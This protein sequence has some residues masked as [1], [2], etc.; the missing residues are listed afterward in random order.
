ME[1]PIFFENLGQ[2]MYGMLHRPDGAQSAPAVVMF[3]GFT[4]H[5]TEVHCL[6]VRA[7]RSLMARGI[8]VLRFDFRGSGESEGEFSQMT[9]DGEVGDGLRAVEFLASRPGVDPARIGV[10]GMS[11]GGCVAACVAA[12]SSRVKAAVLWAAVGDM[13]WLF[14]PYRSRLGQEGEPKDKIDLGGNVISR[15]FVESAC[16]ARRV[17]EVSRFAGPV[18]VLHGSKDTGVPPTDAEKYAQAIAAKAR[19]HMVEGADHQFSSA[20]WT[21]ISY[22][23]P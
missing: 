19:L 2:R 4:G 11:L 15:A 3:H 17:D 21:R 10:I 8:G 18:L 5:R 7:A 12:R 22:D 13:E 6:F 9:V 23:S 16:A 14:S 1:H 20:S